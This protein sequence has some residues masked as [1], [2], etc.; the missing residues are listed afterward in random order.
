MHCPGNIGV[1]VCLQDVGKWASRW[2]S[3]GY[4]SVSAYREMIAREEARV[5]KRDFG[6]NTYTAVVKATL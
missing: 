1:D 5:E 3:G 6:A 4:C 2:Y